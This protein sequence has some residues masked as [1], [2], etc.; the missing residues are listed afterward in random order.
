MINNQSIID[1]NKY[2]S[3]L[4]MKHLLNKGN[5]NKATYNKVREKSKN[6]SK[7]EEVA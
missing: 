6:I 3:T 1:F 2:I 7:R 4:L 5:I